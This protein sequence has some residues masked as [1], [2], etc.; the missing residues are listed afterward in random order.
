MI[1]GTLEVKK[2]VILKNTKS[3]TSYKKA[4]KQKTNS[5]FGSFKSCVGRMR[6]T[7][8]DLNTPLAEI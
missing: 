2:Y 1:H 4:N 7:S 5:P 8:H 3:L 6:E